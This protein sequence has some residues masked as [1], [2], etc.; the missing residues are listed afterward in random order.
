[1]KKTVGVYWGRFNPPHKGH[2]ALVK[3]LVKKVDLLIVAVGNAESKNTKRNPFS[4]DE[5]VKML[6]GYLKE[7][8]IKVEDVVAVEDGNSWASSIDNLFEKCGKF[9][10]LF[11]DHK[12]IARLVGNRVK[13]VSF[14]R[15]GDISST[16]MRDSIAKGE[17]WENLT[18]KSVV[19]LIRRFDGIARIKRAY[20]ATE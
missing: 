12:T 9:E 20:G 17:E 19:S 1:M 15:K 8:D 10:I 11:T 2:I 14:E 7:Q 6:K 13:V 3:R 5:R 4:G 18:G 16:L